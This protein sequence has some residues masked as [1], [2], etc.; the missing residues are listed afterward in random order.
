MYENVGWGTDG[1]VEYVVGGPQ[2]VYRSP[3]PGHLLFHARRH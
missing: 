3:L 2:P 1:A